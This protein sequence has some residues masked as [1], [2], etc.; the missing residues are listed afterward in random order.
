MIAISGIS[1]AGK[2]T[3]GKLLAKE[4]N[5]VFIDQDWFA[6]GSNNKV[7][8]SSGYEFTN[9]DCDESLH[10]KNFNDALSSNNKVVV[11]GFN[12]RDYFFDVENKPIIHFHLNIPKELSLE[13][14]LL[15]KP[16]SDERKNNEISI[17]N[18]YVYPYYEE[19]LKCSKINHY[20][21]VMNNNGKRRT[22]SD[23]LMEITSLL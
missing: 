8:L 16:F 14:R 12:L 13:T 15:I 10:I 18:D 1:G 4:L 20:I 17:F 19:T 2:S 6:R 22:S 9:Y 5:C 21:N 23:I 7:I 11:V 3:I